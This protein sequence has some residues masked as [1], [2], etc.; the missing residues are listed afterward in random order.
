MNLKVKLYAI[1]VDV[2]SI[3]AHSLSEYLNIIHRQFLSGFM[4][5]P[6]SSIYIYIYTHTHI[7]IFFQI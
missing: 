7:Y 1:D 3:S 4:N 6:R 2:H 5:W